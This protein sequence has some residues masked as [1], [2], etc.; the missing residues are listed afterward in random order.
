MNEIK[1]Q[2]SL[3]PEV[4]SE[5][6]RIH[7]RMMLICEKFNVPGVLMFQLSQVE[8]IARIMTSVW[9]PGNMR[10]GKVLAVISEMAKDHDLVPILMRT[11]IDYKLKK[12]FTDAMQKMVESMGDVLAGEVTEE[13]DSQEVPPEFIEFL[14]DLRKRGNHDDPT[15]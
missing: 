6:T 4:E 2:W 11:I 7:E 10:V 14:E 3:P 1:D 13:E 8:D 5:L 15:S 12:S 9:V